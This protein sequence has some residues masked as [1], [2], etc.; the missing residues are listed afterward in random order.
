MPGQII[1]RLG[2]PLVRRRLGGLKIKV[3]VLR[4]SAQGHSPNRQQERNLSDGL[5]NCNWF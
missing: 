1:L 3:G 5:I 4:R 2:I